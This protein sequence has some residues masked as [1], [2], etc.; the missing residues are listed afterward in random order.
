MCLGLVNFGTGGVTLKR[1]IHLYVK[2]AQ[3]RA[4][5]LK[6]MPLLQQHFFKVI[7]L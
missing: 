1:A 5:H 2:M 7:L 4:R 3:Y 6:M